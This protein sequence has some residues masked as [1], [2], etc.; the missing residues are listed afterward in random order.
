[1][2]TVIKIRI[3]PHKKRKLKEIADRN[4]CTVSD[5]VREAINEAVADSEDQPIT[6]KQ[7]PNYLNRSR[8]QPHKLAA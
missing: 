5:F 2:F 4:N 6:L 8:R 7:N 3:T 1:M